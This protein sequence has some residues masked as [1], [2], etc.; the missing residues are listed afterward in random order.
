MAGFEDLIKKAIV[1]QNAQSDPEARQRIYISSRAALERMVAANTALT[2]DAVQAQRAK[3]DSAILE[4]ESS[5]RVANPAPPAAPSPSAAPA[6]FA[7]HGVAQPVSENVPPISQQTPP[8]LQ[9][10]PPI[11]EPNA[12]P[13][14]NVATRQG[15]GFAAA[16]VS[17]PNS[18]F[19]ATRSTPQ[20]VDYTGGGAGQRRPY[21]RMLAWVIILCGLAMAAW[22]S[23]N[24]APQLLKNQIDERVYNPEQPIT[25]GV[26]NPNDDEGWISVFDPAVDPGAIVTENRG[27]A[28]LVQT[29]GGTIAR[30][31]SASSAAQ[32]NIL[33]RIPPGVAEQM[34]GKAVT[35]ELVLSAPADS[36]QQVAIY[37]EFDVLGSCGRKRFEVGRDPTSQIFDVLAEDVSLPSG[38]TAFIAFNTDILGQGRSIDLVGIRMRIGG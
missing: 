26:F 35:F 34:R 32:G 30:L 2:P 36:G 24:F 31:R 13:Q 3:L 14:I 7:P 23:W 16:P 38:R 19:A 17:V 29:D 37:C 21:I 4:I 12:A 28:E 22:W 5:F 18:G 33:I 25:R 11:R 15:A 10:A 9:P 20:P 27:T 6:A 8:I 1:S